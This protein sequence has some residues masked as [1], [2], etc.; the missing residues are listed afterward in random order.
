MDE[1]QRKK[2]QALTVFCFAIGA[3]LLSMFLLQLYVGVTNGWL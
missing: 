2:R 3:F 1:V